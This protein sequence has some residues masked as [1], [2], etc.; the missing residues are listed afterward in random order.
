MSGGAMHIEYHN[1]KVEQYCTD[2]I[3]AKKKFELKI[4]TK[5]MQVINFIEA[6]ES[7]NDVIKYPPF[8]FHDLKGNR[9]GQYAIDIAGRKSKYRLILKLSKSETIDVYAD[10]KSIEVVIIQ[11]VS[12]HC[13]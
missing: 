5:L 13:E 7:L 6:A 12:K 11:E 2:M 8:N 4:A 3:E 10:A 9:K 1:K